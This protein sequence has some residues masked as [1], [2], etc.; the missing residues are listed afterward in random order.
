M[1]AFLFITPTWD[2]K[3]WAAEMKKARPEM[4]VRI[5]PEM[6]QVED[7]HYTAA[8]LPP[9]HV[10]GAL[11]N[12]KVIFSLG[13][14]VDAIL[15]DPTLPAQVPIVRVNDPDLTMRMTEYVVMHVL[16]H[17]RQQRRLDA[18]QVRRE[19]NSFPTH[20]ASALRVG[21]M[22]L[23]VLGQDAARKLALL[24]FQVAGWSRSAKQIE[25][26]VCHSGA[27]GLEA[28]LARTDVLVCLLPATAETDGIINGA[29]IRK[30]AQDGPLGG[31]V[32][33]NAGRGRQ[34]VEADILA[35]LDSGELKA[36]TLDVFRTEPLP[37]EHAFWRHPG[38]TLT[39]HI[40][41]DPIPPPSAP[42]WR[43][44]SRSMR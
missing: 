16:M 10:V 13:A 20:A 26:V 15:S 17:H 37:Q 21:V 9:P 23:G 41:A 39:P 11:P 6:G 2:A 4:D 33:I 43:G 38:V 28:F 19:W 30:L 3:L 7:I 42:M 18:Q 27:A 22:G 1:S 32:I 8:W 14:G 5:W 12:L 24:G 34:Q 44:R 35:A 29:L 40:A 36:V 31:P 25:G